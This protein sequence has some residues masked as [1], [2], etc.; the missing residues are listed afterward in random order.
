VSVE[1]VLTDCDLDSVHV[2][3]EVETVLAKMKEDDE[4]RTGP[5]QGDGT[6][7]VRDREVGLRA[8]GDDGSAGPH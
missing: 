3:M 1:T 8:G 2:G 6:R 4:R 5:L 7:P